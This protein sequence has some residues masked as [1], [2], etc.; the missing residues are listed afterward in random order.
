M[1]GVG[2]VDASGVWAGL[3]VDPATNQ[4]GQRCDDQHPQPGTWPTPLVTSGGAAVDDQGIPH[5]RPQPQRGGYVLDSVGSLTV[6]AS[7][8]R[9]A[10]Q[11]SGGCCRAEVAEEQRWSRANGLSR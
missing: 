1:V 2:P 5:C 8:T 6:S 11:V 3:A 4:C 10:A 9:Q 7:S